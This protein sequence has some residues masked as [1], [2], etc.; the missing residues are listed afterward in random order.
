M[1]LLDARKVWDAVHKSPNGTSLRDHYAGLA[2]QGVIADGHTM[3]EN[4]AFQADP[5]AIA[6]FAFR[7]ADAMLVAR[8]GTDA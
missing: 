4:P 6:G 5:E 3:W 8:D 7:M 2:M 1:A